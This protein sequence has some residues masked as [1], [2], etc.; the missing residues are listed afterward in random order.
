MGSSTENSP[1]EGG[2]TEIETEENGEERFD[3]E[4][5]MNTLNVV[6][7]GDCVPL[8]SELPDEVADLIIADPPYNIG[9]QFGSTRRWN[10]LDEWLPWCDEWIGECARILSPNGSMFVYGIHNYL[11]Y[12]QVKMYALDLKY[13]RQIIW[14]YENGFSGFGKTTLA[15]HYEP[16]LWFSKGKEYTYHT[17]REPYKSQERLKYKVIKNGKTWTPHPDGKMAGDVWKFPTLAGRRFR[18]EKVDHPTQKPLALSDRIVV[19]FS[20]PGDLIVVPFAGSGTECVSALKNGRDF[21]ACELDPGYAQLSQERLA[22][23]EA[24]ASTWRLL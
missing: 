10:S 5:A 4:I 18:D 8:L 14:N 20:D 2:Q 22:G 21:W 7:V 17:I 23:V 1:S 11:A 9:K 6:Q 19:H 3:S 24:T 15:T 12:L 13:R 16:I